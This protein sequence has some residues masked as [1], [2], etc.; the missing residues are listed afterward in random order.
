MNAPVASAL[1]VL[2]VNGVVLVVAA[3]LL[4]LYCP[5]T[6]PTTL[7]AAADVCRLLLH[8]PL[9]LLRQGYCLL[10]EQRRHPRATQVPVQQR[11]HGRQPS[12]QL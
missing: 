5:A 2:L 4:R 9:Q 3:L 1:L 7:A 11:S 8:Q 6:I 10:H 12:G